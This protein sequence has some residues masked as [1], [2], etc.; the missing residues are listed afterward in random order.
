M[1][2]KEIIT[3]ISKKDLKPIYFLMGDEPYYIDKISNE[4]SKKIL[5]TEQQEFNQIILYGK[6]TTAEQIIAES[7]QF[8]FG[9]EKRMVIIEIQCLFSIFCQI[10]KR[11]TLTLRTTLLLI[12]SVSI[13]HL[14][15]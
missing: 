4:F 8:P 6:D 5:S 9:A 10:Q 14:I 1:N 7:K 12:P 2:Y 13:L 3:S 15:F 11:T